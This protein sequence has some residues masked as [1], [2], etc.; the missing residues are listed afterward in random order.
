MPQPH[1]HHHLLGYLLALL[2]ILHRKMCWLDPTNTF[3]SESRKS[4]LNKGEGAAPAE[5]ETRERET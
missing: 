2:S 4:M 5:A 3:V 1:H